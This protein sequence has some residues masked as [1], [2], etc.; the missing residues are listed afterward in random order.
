M[1]QSM[2]MATAFVPVPSSVRQ[3]I[4]F[5]STSAFQQALLLTLRLRVEA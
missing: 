1:Q 2:T 4:V 5:F 3:M